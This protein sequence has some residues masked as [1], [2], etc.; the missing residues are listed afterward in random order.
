MNSLDP[1]TPTY[2]LSLWQKRQAAMLY[3]YSSLDYL[4]A[5]LPQIEQ[6]IAAA[7]MLLERRSILDPLMVSERWGVRDTAANWST[8]G[9][10]ALIAFRESTLWH[11]SKRDDQC[12][13]ITGATQCA[14]MLREY[15]MQWATE[16]QEEHFRARAELVFKY[17]FDIDGVI[18]QRWDDATFWLIWEEK[19]YLFPR[20]PKFKVHLDI[21]GETGKVPGRTG[22][23]I[24]QDDPHGA[25]QFGWTGGGMVF[26]IHLTN[27]RPLTTLDWTR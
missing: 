11:I 13:G 10:P 8:G 4:K 17:A 18:E 6:L 12:Y 23:Y 25:L 19:K 14:R 27:A 5:L 16:E 20:L 1:E 2:H 15:S 9:F 22:V 24:P 21:E 7:E 26:L 3:Y